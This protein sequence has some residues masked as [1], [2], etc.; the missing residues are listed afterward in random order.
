VTVDGVLWKQVDDLLAAPSEVFAGSTAGV[1]NA[2]VYAADSASGQIRFGTGLR[3]ARPPNNSTIVAT[4]AYGGGVAG[5]VGIGAIRSSPQL[6]AGFTVSNP[7]PTQGGTA[8]ESLGEAEK[9]IPLYLQHKDRAVSAADFRDIVE[10]IPGINLGRVEVIPLLLPDAGVT[11]PGVVTLLVIPIDPDHPE[12]PVPDRYFLKAVCDYVEPRRLLTTEAHVCAPNYVDLSVSIGFDALP[13]R[14]IA[15]VRNG[16]QSIIRDFLSPLTGGPD[17]TGWPLGKSVTD[18][19]LLARAARADG[20]SD[21]NDVWIWDGSG[22][23]I[24]SLPIQNLD[25]PRLTRVGAN[26]GDPEDLTATPPPPA[27]TRLPVP[28]LP[29]SC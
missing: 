4:Y 27:K 21:I 6:P 13:G 17:R 22:T 25:L 15:V 11:I 3:G 2:F 18:R 14:D 1:S 16:I 24:T 10:S 5:N 23:R 19:E 12:G 28:V 26:Q 20:L 7:L 9:R 29:L 8:G